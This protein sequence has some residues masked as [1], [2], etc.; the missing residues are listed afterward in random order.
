MF[1]NLT[2]ISE[3]TYSVIS[4]WGIF[5]FE[6]AF[7]RYRTAF[8]HSAT[9]IPL[10]LQCLHCDTFYCNPLGTFTVFISQPNR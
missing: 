1:V 9:T 2:Q 7:Y 4:S 3:N 10:N 5:Q 6:R 8:E